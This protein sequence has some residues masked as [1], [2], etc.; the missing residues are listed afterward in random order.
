MDREACRDIIKRHGLPLPPKSACFFCPAMKRQE[1]KRLAVVDPD[2]YKL[3]IEMER[4]YRD[5]HHFRGD[6]FWTVTARLKEFEGDKAPDPI[7]FVCEADN[8]AEAR[9]Q[10]RTEYNDQ[11]RPYKYKTSCSPA[12]P[13]LGRNFA[14]KDVSTELVQLQS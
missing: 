5:G 2:Y 8:A 11:K 13:G 4:L 1:I 9:L 7:K 14:W 12:V 3:A 10:F 6:R